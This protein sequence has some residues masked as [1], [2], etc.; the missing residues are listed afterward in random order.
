MSIVK[1]ASESKTLQFNRFATIIAAIVAA[2][3]TVISFVVDLFA[4][5]EIGAAIAGFIPVE[6]RALVLLVVAFVAKRN[7]DLRRQTTTPIQGTPAAAEHAEALQRLGL[8]EEVIA[9]SSNGDNGALER[10][11]TGGDARKE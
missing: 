1:P 6:Y 10:F 4:D 9:I 2:A 11:L 8:P 5:P 3:P 7:S